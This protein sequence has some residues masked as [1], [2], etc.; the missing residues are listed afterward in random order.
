MEKETMATWKA[1]VRK[2]GETIVVGVPKHL[3]DKL[4]L[5]VGQK[6]WLSYEGKV[7]R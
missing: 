5:Q 4:N 1:S 2:V 7:R 3:V 6:V